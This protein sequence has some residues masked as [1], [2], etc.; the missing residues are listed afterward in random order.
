MNILAFGAS[1]SKASINQKLA[2]FAAS[3]FE[4]ANTQNLNLNDY[5]APLFSIDEETEN[6][7]PPQIHAFVEQIKQADF[8]IISLAEH[9]GT[10]TVAFKN[11]FD[12]ATRVKI[13]LFE[14]KKMLLLATS[15][16][17]RGGLGVLEAA[18]N[19][20][21]IHGADI[22]GS[23]SLPVFAENFEKDKGITSVLLQKDFEKVIQQ[24]KENYKPVLA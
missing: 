8:L 2:F 1:N 22:V 13:N 19:R 10:Y 23:F 12:W 4:G 15:P 24:A 3:Q 20:F 11:I 5:S 6:G 21:P 14:N 17:P 7:I 16:G 18:Q 9:N